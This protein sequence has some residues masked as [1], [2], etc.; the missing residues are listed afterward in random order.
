MTEQ[1]YECDAP[2][3]IRGPH[4]GL[5][6]S[7]CPQCR[8]VDPPHVCDPIECLHPSHGPI[9]LPGE[10]VRPD[11]SRAGTYWVLVQLEVPAE[12]TSRRDAERAAVAWVSDASAV[13][14]LP[15]SRVRAVG[16]RGPVEQDG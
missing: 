14:G 5:G 1:L 9:D 10:S 12:G 6:F 16:S 4:G 11:A 15:S 7:P 2:G 8:P 3:A 13:A